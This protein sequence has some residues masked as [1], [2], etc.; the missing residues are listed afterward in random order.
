[1]QTDVTRLGAGRGTP[2]HRSTCRVLQQGA[3]AEPPGRPTRRS[4]DSWR[5]SK[6]GT[7][8]ARRSR[9]W[10]RTR[11]HGEDSEGAESSR[12]AGFQAGCRA[13]PEKTSNGPAKSRTSTSSKTKMPTCNCASCVGPPLDMP[14][15]F[16]LIGPPISPFI[17]RWFASLESRVMSPAPFDPHPTVSRERKFSFDLSAST[18]RT[19]CSVPGATMQP[20]RTCQTPPSIAAK[21]RNP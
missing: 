16:R 19:T 10:A 8:G 4:R 7:T 13:S 21:T 11:R 18:T 6:C 5:R 3:G 2:H 1:V 20:G 17:P 14:I 12:T 15:G 9:R